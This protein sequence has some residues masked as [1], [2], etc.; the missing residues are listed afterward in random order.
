MTGETEKEAEEENEPEKNTEEEE[1]ASMGWTPKEDWRG[2]PE[3]WKD[4]ETFNKDGKQIHGALKKKVDNLTVRLEAQSRTMK[5]LNAHHE[6]MSARQKKNHAREMDALKA[7]QRAAATAEDMDEFDRLEKERTE[8]AK[9]A[10][11]E[12]AK[13]AAP[14]L[15]PEVVAWEKKN[16]WFQKDEAMAN[17]AIARKDQLV[18]EFPGLTFEEILEEVS[19]DVRDRF[20][21]KFGKTPNSRRGRP[22]AVEGA[23]NAGRKKGGKTW[24]DLPSDA[25]KAADRFIAEGLFGG[26]RENYLKQYEWD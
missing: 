9:D 19:K 18:T 21:E 7:K 24:N 25:Q 14:E 13:V 6:K 23:S 26:K 4:A 11:E 5:D 20:P 1:A 3:Q 17:Y 2:D 16:P 12:A 15:P 10:P 22:A 8:L